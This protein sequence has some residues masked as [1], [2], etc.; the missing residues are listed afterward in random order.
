MDLQTFLKSHEDY[1]RKLLHAAVEGARSGGESFLDGKP[2]VA[3]LDE[4]TR[5]AW[6]PAALGACIGL[7]GSYPD[8]QHRSRGRIFASAFVGGVIG[9][10]T[11]MVWQNRHLAARVA[12][13]VWRKIG[14][15]RDE[16]WL[17]KNPIDY[18]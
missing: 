17:E 16:H 12:S 3:L 2:L 9:F 4:S 5:N 11:G 7:L 18:A 1:S 15:V 6:K 8:H 14:R 13:E 10:G